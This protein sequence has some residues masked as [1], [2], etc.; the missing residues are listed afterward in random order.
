MPVALNYDR[1]LARLD[2]MFPDERIDPILLFET[3]RGCWWGERA[4][5]TFCGLNGQTMAYRTMP[6][7]HARTLIKSL[8]R[9]SSRVSK[10]QCVDNIM[11]KNYPQEVFTDLETPDNVSIFY[12]V[13]ADLTEDEVK[14]LA[15]ARVR[16]VQPG[17]EALAT[18]TLKLMRKGTTVFTNLRFLKLCATHD[19]VPDWSLLIGFPDEGEEVYRK[20]VDDIPN[21]VHLPPPGGAYPVRPDRYS[22]YHVRAAEYGMEL[23]PTDFYEL[24]Y[25]FPP[26]SLNKLAYFFRDNNFAADYFLTMV[27]WYEPV[28][29]VV[30]SWRARWEPARFAQPPMLYRKLVGGRTVVCDTRSDELLE[31]PLDAA[32]TAVLASLGRP[33]RLDDVEAEL[34]DIPNLNLDAVLESLDDRGLLFIERNQVMSLVLDAAPPARS[35]TLAWSW[36]S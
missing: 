36:A 24:V 17:I 33:R 7:E 26:E 32:S 15:R 20:Y 6:A 1:F 13:K 34:R 14:I 10:L 3:S 22:P 19:I 28:K 21:L 4:H 16:E 5:C 8:F 12:E 35:D 25:P 30:D 31:Y 9:H 29:T 23:R 2:Q 11:P 27:Q 18:S